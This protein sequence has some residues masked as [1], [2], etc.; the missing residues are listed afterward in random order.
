MKKVFFFKD[1]NM[2]YDVLSNFN[3]QSFS[4]KTVPLKLHMGEMKNKYFVKPD[5]VKHVVDVLKKFD[6]KPFLFD[7]TVA[8]QAPRHY[9]KGYEK[10]AGINGFS[11][12][13]IGCD[14]VIDDKGF[15]VT[16][17]NHDYEV[18]E[19][20]YRSSHIFGLSHVKGHISTGMG[21]AIKNF[22]MGGVTK[23]TKKEIHDGSSPVYNVDNCNYCG[24]CAE[25]CPFNALEV[26]KNKWKQNTGKCFGCGVCV[27]N[28]K[29][30]ALSFSDI[31]LQHNIATAAKAVVQNKNAIYLNEL[32]RIS[33]N[34]DCVPNGGP[35]ICPDIGYL[36]SDDLVAADKASLDL[37]HS[38]K[39]D[40]FEKENSINPIKQIEYGEEIGLGSS[41]YELIRI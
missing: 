9:K 5:M 38:V 36:V 4:N 16:I 6:V 22:G 18:A 30:N 35:I 23:E 14:V 26:T 21:G 19:H 20:I 33:K 8:Y 24:V 39:P 15:N 2:L 31:D 28:C 37:I 11:N 40:V 12:K 7:T 10:I 27:N 13:K 3:I 32:K 25:V 34:C 41:S 17:G 29:E 1:I